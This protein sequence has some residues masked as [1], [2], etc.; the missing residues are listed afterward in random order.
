MG[1][2]TITGLTLKAGVWHIDKVVHGVGRIRRSTG[3]STRAQAEQFLLKRIAEAQAI[4][5]EKRDSR[6]TFRE[7]ATRYLKEY[8][9]QPS[10]WHTGTYLKQLD[11]VHRRAV[12]G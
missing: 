5:A 11:P 12:S 1:Q 6:R 3:T 7:A 10:I 2:K 8:A 4:K 9:Q